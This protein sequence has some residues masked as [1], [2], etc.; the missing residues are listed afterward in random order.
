MKFKIGDKVVPL[1]NKVTTGGI[2]YTSHMLEFIGLE[3]EVIEL[4]DDRLELSNG[5]YYR[6]EWLEPTFN[7]VPELKPG[8]RVRTVDGGIYNLFFLEGDVLKQ[9][10]K[11]GYFSGYNLVKLNRSDVNQVLDNQCKVLWE[12]KEKPEPVEEL[13]VEQVESK[14]GYKIKIVADKE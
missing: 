5:Y 2:L 1:P 9:T 4:Y 12:Y 10:S 3:L 13:T 11:P 6:P 8:M 14:L 7:P